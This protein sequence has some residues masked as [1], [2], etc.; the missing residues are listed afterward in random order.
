C[1]QA[2]NYGAGLL[3]ALGPPLFPEGILAAQV[4]IDLLS[5]GQVV[6]DRS[7]DFLKAESRVLLTNRL[8]RVSLLKGCHDRIKHH[9]AFPDSQHAIL[10]RPYV[11]LRL[12]H[13]HPPSL[14]PLYQRDT[15]R[16]DQASKPR[17]ED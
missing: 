1:P 5:V 9:P 3:L 10:V 11:L 17:K 13:D 15:G 7:V 4:F 12:A 8:R 14:A 6:S 16:G 2:V